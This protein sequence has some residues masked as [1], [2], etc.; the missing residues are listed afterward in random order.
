ME[1]G[2]LDPVEDRTKL[3][4]FDAN[5]NKAAQ[6]GRTVQPPSTRARIW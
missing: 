2:A 3:F 5:A 4:S 6:S 1:V